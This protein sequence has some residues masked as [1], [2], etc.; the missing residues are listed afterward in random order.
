MWTIRFLVAIGILLFNCPCWADGGYA[1]NMSSNSS[2]NTNNSGN[3]YQ[4]VQQLP[5]APSFNN[6]FIPPNGNNGWQAGLTTIFGGAM[7]GKTKMDKTNQDLNQAN[8]DLLYIQGLQMVSQCY[9][10]ECNQY[11]AMVYNRFLQRNLRN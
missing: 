11:R 2:Y 4:K 6:T 10:P 7:I 9:S 1:D 8:A 3:F 5:P